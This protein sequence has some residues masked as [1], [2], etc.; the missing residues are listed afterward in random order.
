M[1][2]AEVAGLKADR[3]RAY[4]Q[5]KLL[6]KPGVA[7]H[8][9]RVQEGKPPLM[10]GSRVRY[11]GH[12]V[13]FEGKVSGSKVKIEAGDKTIA[14]VVF[15]KGPVAEEVVV[16]SVDV[17]AAGDVEIEIVEPKDDADAEGEIIDE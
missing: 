8:I 9:K 2:T 15:Y 7:D 5:E 12:E 10:A 3:F 6:R 16:G 17:N 13:A 4:A 14:R 1:L 11:D